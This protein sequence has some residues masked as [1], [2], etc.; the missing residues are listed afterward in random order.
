M[1]GVYKFNLVVSKEY[2]QNAVAEYYKVYS[3]AQQFLGSLK[4]SSRGKLWLTKII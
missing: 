1:T 4:I 2:N 3:L